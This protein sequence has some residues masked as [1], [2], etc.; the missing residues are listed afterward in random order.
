MR[1]HPNDLRGET[2]SSEGG[3]VLECDIGSAG[4]AAVGVTLAHQ[5]VAH[6]IDERVRDGPN[7]TRG[8]SLGVVDQSVIR[9]AAG[10]LDG[11]GCVVILHVSTNEQAMFGA[12]IVVNFGNECVEV[13]GVRRGKR[14]GSQVIAIGKLGAIRRWKLSIVGFGCRVDAWPRRAGSVA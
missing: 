5:P 13:Y 10:K 6:V 1:R 3:N 7:I 14:I 11:A 2:G 8:D 4:D 9:R 12:E